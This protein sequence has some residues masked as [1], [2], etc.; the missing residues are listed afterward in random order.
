M[1][2][3][4]EKRQNICIKNN[5]KTYV[6]YQNIVRDNIN[7]EVLAGKGK[8]VIYIP[9]DTNWL[10]VQDD[11]DKYIS[12]IIGKGAKYQKIEDGSFGEFYL[13]SN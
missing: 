7:A 5:L 13:I 3:F 1:L 6:K 2:L 4:Q 8:Y 11:T 10:N 9:T 12:D